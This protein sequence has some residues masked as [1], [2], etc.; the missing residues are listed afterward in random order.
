MPEP[1]TTNQRDSWSTSTGIIEAWYNGTDGIDPL[2]PVCSLYLSNPD[3]S[4]PDAYRRIIYINDS[5]G[6]DSTK[7][8]DYIPRQSYAPNAT[9]MFLICGAI[10][11][12][13]I[14]VILWKAGR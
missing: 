9:D 8:F 11:V 13:L 4:S 1:L 10:I 12:F 6:V 7:E 14:L 3:T 5:G 2:L